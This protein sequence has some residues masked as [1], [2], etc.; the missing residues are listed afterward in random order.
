MTVNLVISQPKTRYTSKYPLVPVYIVHIW[1][2][3]TPPIWVHAG[4]HSPTCLR[5]HICRHMC[6]HAPPPPPQPTNHR[7]TQSHTDTHTHAYATAHKHRHTYAETHN[8]T[9]THTHTH[10]CARAQVRT[11]TLSA[12][13]CTIWNHAQHTL[14]CFTHALVTHRN[15]STRIHITPLFYFVAV[16][17]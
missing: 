3:P 13:M 15:T 5:T 7:P 17:G 14:L 9:H 12:Q 10:T 4:T 2:W 16:S 11:Y 1:F 8:H 6:T